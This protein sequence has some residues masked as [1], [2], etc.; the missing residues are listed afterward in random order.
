MPSTSASSG[1]SRG[2]GG[3]RALFRV[4]RIP[5]TPVLLARRRNLAESSRSGHWFTE[6]TE[7]IRDSCST[8]RTIFG[9]RR[10]QSSTRVHRPCQR[11]GFNAPS[12]AKSMLN[13]L[14][15]AGYVTV[16]RTVSEVGAHVEYAYEAVRPSLVETDVICQ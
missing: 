1:S 14:L 4:A 16:V 10:K 11:R 12:S 13:G 6:V 2:R 8:L 7:K 9:P 3:E 5:S 15:A